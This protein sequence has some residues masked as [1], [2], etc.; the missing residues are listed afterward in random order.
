MDI[1]DLV[2]NAGNLTDYQFEQKLH[3]L[4]RKNYKF[5]NLGTANQQLILNLVKK[6]KDYIR[7]GQGIPSYSRD[8]EYYH[9]YQNRTQLGLTEEDVKDIKEI[10]A[11]LGK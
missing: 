5:Q 2:K 10:M 9:L 3:E 8:K 1:K 11:A 4:V 7:R 6:Y